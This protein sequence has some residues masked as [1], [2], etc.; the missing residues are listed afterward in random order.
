MY[1]YLVKVFN[2]HFLDKDYELVVNVENIHPITVKLL[3]PS[4]SRNIHK[5]A[6]ICSAFLE[7]K[8]VSEA[9]ITILTDI[10]ENNEFD[11]AKIP[12]FTC[13]TDDD[14]T[15]LDG[16]SEKYPESFLSFMSN[17]KRKLSESTNLVIDA[18]LWR[19]KIRHH[20]PLKDTQ[21]FW[22]TDNS[23]WH[24]SPLYIQPIRPSLAPLALTSDEGKNDVIEIV[25]SKQKTP[26]HHN[27]YRE[28][29]AQRYSN[30]RS[31][32][33]IGISSLEVAVR[34]IFRLLK[35]DVSW[36]VDEQKQAPPVV[37]LLK[38]QLP[39]LPS[40]NTINGRVL[41]PPV[42]IMTEIEKGVTSRNKIIHRGLNPP[43]EASLVKKLCAIR[44]V[45][46]LI[47]YYCGHTWAYN[48]IRHSTQ[49]RLNNK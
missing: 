44:D 40:I 49:N 47:D 8:K 7:R 31:S 38:E 36:I 33:V 27:L 24:I 3:G 43:I 46:W 37:D 2:G 29:W 35:P 13:S 17:V 15:I 28:A 20:F 9:N 41:P 32:I 6:T 21:M 1:F 34:D 30:P 19:A 22:S 26:I 10:V 23:K 48:F 18:Y 12:S 14:L 5:E 42:E 16:H 45:L 11:P 39:L 4:D 25:N